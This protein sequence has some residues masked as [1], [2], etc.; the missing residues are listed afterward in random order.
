MDEIALGVA[1]VGR[2]GR[3]DVAHVSAIGA[4]ISTSYKNVRLGTSALT[5]AR[6]RAASGVSCETE[7]RMPR[8]FF[9][10]HILTETL[11]VLIRMGAAFFFFAGRVFTLF[12]CHAVKPASLQAARNVATLTGFE[13]VFSP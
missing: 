5:A 8:Q 3:E 10:W 6:D 9:L 12:A 2:D 7:M 4:G 1:I 13:P 11:S